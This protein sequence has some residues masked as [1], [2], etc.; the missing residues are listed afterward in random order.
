M[1]RERITI[2]F[3]TKGVAFD[4]APATEIAKVLRRMA[5]RVEAYGYLPAPRNGRGKVIG[6][7]QVEP[8]N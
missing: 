1:N 4:R 5:D 2:I 7:L 8:L 6:T 3:E